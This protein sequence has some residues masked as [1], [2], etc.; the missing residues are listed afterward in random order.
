MAEVDELQE[1]SSEL[2]QRTQ[3]QI[4][5][6]LEARDG[7]ARFSSDHWER[8]S[9][10]AGQSGGGGESRVLR[11]GALFEQAGVNFSA[12]KGILP[13]Q[14]ASAILQTESE[15][16]FFATGVSLVLHPRSPMVPTVHANFRFIRAGTHAWFGGGADLTPYYLFE[17]DCRH[18][19]RVWKTACD[20]HDPEFY[21]RF[22]RW[23]DE[24]FYLPHRGETR[25]VGGIFFDHLG[26]DDSPVQYQRFMETVSG[27]FLE[28]YLPIVDRRRDEPWG[29]QER[30]FQLLRRGRYAEFNLL[31]D[32]GT[33]FGLRTGGRTESIMMSLPPV[34]RWEYGH[35][36]PAGSREAELLSLLRGTPRDWAA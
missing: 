4:C 17:E 2:F 19:H 8:P 7:G 25:G 20:A 32:R 6:A 14:V 23:C 26:K 24:Y 16:E 33:Q 31:Y 28:S 29:E 12:V 22:K 30:E 34:A 21:P 35:Q 15:T 10:V 9:E 1:W 5:E 13:S 27:A 18:F 36:A 11:N 3:R